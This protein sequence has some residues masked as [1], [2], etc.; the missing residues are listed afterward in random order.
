[1]V[2]VGGRDSSAVVASL[3]RGVRVKLSHRGSGA[4]PFFAPKSTALAAASSATHT[5]GATATVAAAGA[6]AAPAVWRGGE[7]R[8]ALDGL[9]AE[10]VEEL[11][12][13]GAWQPRVQR[14]V[15]HRAAPSLQ[16]CP[17]LPRVCEHRAGWWWRRAVVVGG[18]A[19]GRLC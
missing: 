13:G 6:R 3:R 10:R 9:A 19:S 17:Q 18:C 1:M 12:L 7:E 16:L 2:V 15:R 8:R 11:A 4:A 5:T 14:R